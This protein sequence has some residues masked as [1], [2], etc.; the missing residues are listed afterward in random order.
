MTLVETL[1]VNGKR[2]EMASIPHQYQ[3]DP[4][5]LFL[6]HVG[7]VELRKSVFQ[8]ADEETVVAM[9]FLRAQGRAAKYSCRLEVL[10]DQ[11]RHRVSDGVE[12]PPGLFNFELATQATMILSEREYSI[13]DAARLRKEEFQR[14]RRIKLGQVA[15]T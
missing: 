2:F 15:T 13:A 10:A 5:P 12:G 1:T 14:L 4:F 8:V 11:S 9:Y 6:W 3:E 7:D